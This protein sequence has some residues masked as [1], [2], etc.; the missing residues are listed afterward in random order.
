MT[1]ISIVQDKE[2][3]F[4]NQ[5]TLSVTNGKSLFLF[6]LRQEEMD[7][8]FFCGVIPMITKN[9]NQLL[10]GNKWVGM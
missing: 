9:T 4:A 1:Y 2:L 6:S 10:F 8:Y 3:T 5:I 7:I